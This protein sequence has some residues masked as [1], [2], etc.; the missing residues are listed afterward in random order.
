VD[1]SSGAWARPDAEALADA[2]L[3]VAQRP[4]AER[5]LAARRRAEAYSWDSAVQAMLE[6]HGSVAADQVPRYA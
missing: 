2:V 6:I 1:A 5:R 3:L 4:L